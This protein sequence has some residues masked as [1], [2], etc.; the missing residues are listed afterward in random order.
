M[1]VQA[2]HA[3]EKKRKQGWRR[4][5]SHIVELVLPVVP[6]PKLVT[7]INVAVEETQESDSGNNKEIGEREMVSLNQHLGA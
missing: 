6:Q 7:A 2:F 5:A 4:L 1:P 3:K